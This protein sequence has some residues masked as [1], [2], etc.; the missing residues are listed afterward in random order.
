MISLSQ[1][2]VNIAQ[3]RKAWTNLKIRDYKNISS[4]RSLIELGIAA[5]ASGQSIGSKVENYLK[6][7]F[8]WQ[9]PTGRNVGDVL[10]KRGKKIEIKFSTKFIGGKQL[11]RDNSEVDFYL[12]VSCLPDEN[13]EEHYFLLS[14]EQLKAE[15]QLLKSKTSYSTSEWGYDIR[16]M[17][18]DK[19]SLSRW[20]H[21]YSVSFND[22]ATL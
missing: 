17:P 5:S 22:L 2:L 16:F 19:T 9:T 13:F 15:S 6:T 4:L 11:L 10:T 20:L 7:E 21:N 14:P 3:F 12:L 18:K 1:H 8:Y